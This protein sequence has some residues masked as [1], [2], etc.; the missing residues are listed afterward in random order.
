MMSI[1]LDDIAILNIRGVDYRC[2]INRI[3]ETEAVNLLQNVDLTEK[4]KRRN[5]NKKK[6]YAI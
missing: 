3:S 2:I 1:N 5:K 4:R 6:Y